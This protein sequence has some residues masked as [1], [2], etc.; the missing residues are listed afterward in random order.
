MAHHNTP[1]ES[2][3]TISLR[4]LRCQNSYPI[5]EVR[6][7]CDCGSQLDVW[8]DLEAL[9][10]LV[11]R[12]LFDGRLSSWWMRIVVGALLLA[13]ILLQRFLVQGLARRA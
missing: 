6:Y 10:P 2:S 13:F 5:D 1:L 8:H 4:C 7:L 9:R 3:S 12:G 11:S